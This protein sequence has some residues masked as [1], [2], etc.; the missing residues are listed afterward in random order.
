MNK[1]TRIFS[2]LGILLT[3]LFAL[4]TLINVKAAS[5]S[6]GKVYLVDFF[7]NF[8]RE[9]FTL[10]SGYI[11][12]GNNLLYTTLEVNENDLV[13][14][15]T[16]PVHTNYR[17]DGWFLEKNCQNEWNFETDRV[18]KNTRLFAKWSIVSEEK[19]VEPPF[20]PPSTILDAEAETDYVIDSIMHFKIENNE[21]KVSTSALTKL[22][23]NKDN[24][25]PLMEYRIKEGKTIEATYDNNVIS[26]KCGEITQSIEVIDNSANFIVTSSGDYE[27]KAK[28]YEA[29][30]LEEESYHVML[31]GSSSIEFWTTSEEDLDPIISYNHGIGG[32]T[33]EEWD[34][35]L[36]QRLVYPYKP[37]MVVYYV[38]INNVINS[39]QNADTI[40][41]NFVSLMDHTHEA[42]P[43]TKVQY[44][45]MNLLTGYPQY[46]ETIIDVNNRIMAYQK[47]NASWLTLIDPGLKL[48]KTVAPDKAMSVNSKVTVK[49]NI[50]LYAQWEDYEGEITPET[51]TITF[52]SNDG[53]GEMEDV[54]DV[55]GEYTLPAN[56]F[57]APEGKTFVGWK[58]NGQ[59]KTYA[60]GTK[61]K[62]YSNI[63]LVA[64]W[65]GAKPEQ[66]VET[67]KVYFH[68]N[69]GTGTME[70]I[71]EVVGDYRLPG[72][73]YTAPEGKR[74]AGWKVYGYP[75]AAY[76]RID[77][78]HL[79]NYGYVIWGGII[80][81][82]ILNGLMN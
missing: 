81:Q 4:T 1:R 64:Q 51:Y 77:G 30:A 74:F 6:E 79:S 22:D 32:T 46:F 3:S 26:V 11:G 17:F 39:K 27:K 45:L 34:K 24:V 16:D 35:C 49:S 33:I 44:I 15:P 68:P 10:S 28:N 57:T 41:A 82:S 43:N 5:A 72:S 78:L 62:V 67:F 38:G 25:L 9:D 53:T 60:A 40:Y 65:Q 73:G 18:T 55:Y 23:A 69:G 80:K 7:S 37:K 20:T 48:L 36:N 70:T 2:H 52:F 63:V 50:E 76:F 56:T 8:D 21:I 29:K 42:M 71:E 58:V 59:G 54:T 61:I 47:E 14:K 31:A 13:T 75:N 12:K 66:A 19:A